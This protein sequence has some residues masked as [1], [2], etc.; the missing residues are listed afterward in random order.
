MAVSKYRKEQVMLNRARA[1]E[2][3]QKGLSLR[4][5]GKIVGMSHAWV[6]TAVDEQEKLST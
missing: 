3:Y 6:K 2:L 5:V 1:L 4:A